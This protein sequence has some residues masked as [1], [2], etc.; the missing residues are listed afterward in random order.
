MASVCQST[1][2]RLSA[3]ARLW[4]VGCLPALRELGH[5]RTTVSGSGAPGRRMELESLGARTYCTSHGDEA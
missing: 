5:G 3:F 1:P 4:T 2:V